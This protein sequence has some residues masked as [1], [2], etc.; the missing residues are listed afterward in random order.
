MTFR[1]SLY[2]VK[3]KELILLAKKCFKWCYLTSFLESFYSYQVVPVGLRIKTT[4]CL[5]IIS[6]EFDK[7]WRNALGESDLKLMNALIEEHAIS[8]LDSTRTFHKEM[9][10]LQNVCDRNAFTNWLCKLNV[11]IEKLV[12]EKICDL[13]MFTAVT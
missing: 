9:D 7:S 1:E 10:S 3:D 12:L 5:P 11:I 4:P 6:E 8:Y 2:V 13:L